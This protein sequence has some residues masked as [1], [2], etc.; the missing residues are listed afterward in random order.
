MT[1]KPIPALAL[2]LMLAGCPTLSGGSG[3]GRFCD[4]ERPPVFTEPSIAAKSRAELEADAA[5]LEYGERECG[6]KAT[7]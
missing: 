1:N 2:C 4:V 7:R 5:R 3:G 6:W